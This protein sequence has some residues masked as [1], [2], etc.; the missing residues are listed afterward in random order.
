MEI[1]PPELE[2]S[3]GMEVYKSKTAGIGGALKALPEDFTVEEIGIDGGLA[4]VCNPAEAV[5]EDPGELGDNLHL[6]M[7]KYNWDT[8]RA[9]KE[10]AKRLH[11]S[12]GRIGYAGTKDKRAVT[13]QRISIWKMRMEDVQRVQI[14]DILLRDYEY[15]DRR[16]ELGDLEGNRFTV[17]VRDLGGDLGRVGERINAVIGELYGQ[18]PAFYGVQ[19]FGTTRPITHL[20]GREIVKGDFYGALMVYL[21]KDYP[22]EKAEIR[23]ARKRLMET[24]DFREALKSFPE[25]LGYENAMLNY[26]VQRPEDYVGAFRVLPKNLS[27]MFV[28]AYQGYIYNRALSGYIR[29]GI[30][31]ERLP[32][33][34]FATDLDEITAELIDEEGVELEQFRVCRA[35]WMGSKGDY[36]ECFT[37]VEDFELVDVS[38]DELNSGKNKAVMRFSLQKGNYATVLLREIMK[39]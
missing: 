13:A 32:L 25:R 9:V 21:A 5:E 36:R 2:R 16:I 34:G 8:M 39:N 6:T 33:P 31:V 37:P 22:G 19:R 23:E 24:G 38:A 4:G 20:V 1:N 17:V 27:M 26:L 7:Q 10:I 12:V 3:L 11:V 30:P 18:V 28:H 29:R 14:K 15:S 35:P